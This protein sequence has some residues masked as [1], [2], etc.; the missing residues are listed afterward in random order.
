M[1]L[2]FFDTETT[3]LIPQN[4][5]LI[6]LAA[7][8]IENGKIGKKFNTLVRPFSDIPKETETITGIKNDDLKDAPLLAKVRTDF[9]E[10]YLQPGDILIAHNVDFDI[11]FLNQKEFDLEYPLIDTFDLAT[12][13][14]PEAKSFALEVFAQNLGIKHEN[15]HRALSDAEASFGLWR[16]MQEKVKKTWNKEVFERV[17]KVLAKAD[18]AGKV[19]FEELADYFQKQKEAPQMTLFDV[20]ATAEAAN[21]VFSAQEEEVARQIVEKSL[22]NR[23][24]AVEVPA[25]LSGENCAFLVAKNLSGRV[26]LSGENHFG[27]PVFDR[28]ENFLCEAKLRDFLKKNHYTKAEAMLYIKINVSRKSHIDEFS[29]RG[30]EFDLF[31]TLF[32]AQ[33]H[34]ICTTNCPALQAQKEAQSAQKVFA[35]LAALPLLEGGNLVISAA[36]KLDERITQAYETKSTSRIFEKLDQ[37]AKKSA[38]KEFLDGLFFGFG[39][40]AKYARE[41]TQESLYPESFRISPQDDHSLD[42]QN[43]GDGFREAA[44]NLTIF[45]PNENSLREEL[46]KWG[47]FFTQEASENEIKILTVFPD[48]SV[49]FAVQPIDLTDKINA[50]FAAREKVILLA[51]NFPKIPENGELTFPFYQSGFTLFSSP[52]AF[53]FATQALFVAPAANGENDDQR[54]AVRVADQIGLLAEAI[55]GNILC[56]LSSVA[57]VENAAAFLTEKEV[58]VITHSFGSINKTAELFRHTKGKKVLLIPARQAE[59]FLANVEDVFQGYFLQKLSF[60]PPNPLWEARKAPFQNAFIEFVLPRAISAFLRLFNLAVAKKE[61]FVFYCADSKITAAN[62]WGKHFFDALPEPLPKK[63]VDSEKAKEL[64]KDFFS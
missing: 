52:P 33:A 44:N 15:A 8:R 17:Q 5:D 46:L 58:V 55:D 41:K 31:R 34:D 27:L 49:A 24:L 40:V 35:P 54:S 45:F 2:V 25:S 42:F 12:L 18:W 32:S 50:L 26:V 61:K 63:F 4:A 9:C 3:G 28:A 39:L 23:R 48:N 64:I 51:D 7:I 56:I 53:D 62:S 19:F 59:R 36:D 10:K 16:A 21:F 1:A 22:K 14:F 37:K 29:L 11:G 57:L 38:Q 47:E 43:F 13:V 30:E 60:D 6:E 20:M